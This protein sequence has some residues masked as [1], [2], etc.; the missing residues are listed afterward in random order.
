V[1]IRFFIFLQGTCSPSQRN[2]ATGARLAHPDQLSRPL[3]A[4]RRLELCRRCRRRGAGEPGRTAAG[5]ATTTTAP[6]PLTGSTSA[7]LT[8][9]PFTPVADKP[10]VLTLT[11]TWTG[12][13][14]LLRSVNNGTTKLPLT[15]AGAPWAVYTANACEPV[16]EE[17]EAV[18]VFYLQFAPTSGTITYRL[19]Q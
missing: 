17:A 3:C 12:T 10:L 13:V 1:P 11:G 4:W 16:W 8:A 5:A 18:A 15:L 19:A 9:G 7:A 2:S 6:A 14:K